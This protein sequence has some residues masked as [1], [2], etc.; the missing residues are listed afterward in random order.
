VKFELLDETNEIFFLLDSLNSLNKS[1]TK[2]KRN[3]GPSKQGGPS[4][5]TTNAAQ[6]K[7]KRTATRK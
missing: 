2:V 3:T 4:A 6:A 7:T 5:S 1:S